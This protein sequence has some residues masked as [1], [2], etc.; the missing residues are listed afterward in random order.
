MP[1]CLRCARDECA[2]E[3]AA[4]AAAGGMPRRCF[5]RA[6]L[7]YARAAA[8]DAR[9]PPAH[10]RSAD[11]APLSAFAADASARLRCRQR[12]MRCRFDAILPPML[13]ARCAAATPPF[14]VTPR[15]AADIC[16]AAAS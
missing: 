3:R 12:Q 7:R 6:L 9:L 13:A 5:A 16:H 1:L 10:E 11:S 2:H 8:V 14:T 15:Y 4:A